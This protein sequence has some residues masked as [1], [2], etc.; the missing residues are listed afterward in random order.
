MPSNTNSTSV[1]I[2]ER[3]LAAPQYALRSVEKT[4]LLLE[5]L[6]ALTAGHRRDCNTYQRILD[7]LGRTGA[8]AFSDLAD[9]P[10]LPVR[11][12]KTMKLQSAKDTEI[13]KILT[14]SGTT[15]QQVS[16]IAVDRTTSLLQTRALA[17]IMRS[18]IGP[19]RLPMIIVDSS[20]VLRQRDS[21]NARGAGLVGMSN[22]GRDHLYVLDEDLRLNVPALMTF[23]EKHHGSE[24]LVFGFTFMVWQYFYQELRRTGDVLPLEQAVLIH[25]GGWKKLQ[26]QAVNHAVFKESLRQVCGV[27]RIHNFYGMVEQVGSIYMECEEGYFHAPHVADV[28]IRDHRDWSVLPFG[29][30]GL[31]QTLSVLP[32]S[33]PGHS[34]LTEDMAIAHGVDD[35][36]CGRNGLRFTVD[37]RMPRAELRGCSDTHAFSL[38]PVRDRPEEVRQFLPRETQAVRIESV[39]GEDLFACRPLD[40]GAPLVMDFLDT[41]SSDLLALQRVKQFPELVALAFW[42]RKSNIR[43]IWDGFVASL[44]SR[45]LAKARGMVLHIA[46]S[47][48]DTIFLYS[49]ALSLLAGNLNIVRVSRNVGQ[50]MDSLVCVLRKQMSDARW[51]PIA[52]RNRLV[53]YPR[54]ERTNRFLSAHA[55]VR[56]I[57]GGDDT[58]SAIRSVPAKPGTKDIAFADKVSATIV[59]A[60]AY[61][62]ADTSLVTSWMRAF[63]NDAYQF[64]QLACSSPHFVFFVG[65]EG[66]CE[67]ASERFWSHLAVHVSGLRTDEHVSTATDKLVAT[68]EL[69]GRAN[70]A[71][72]VCGVGSNAPVVTRIPLGEVSRSRSRTGGGFFVEC[73]IAALEDLAPVV[74]PN[75]QTLTYM[76]FTREDMAAAAPVLC[77][78]GIDRIVPVGQA[79]AFS[80]VWDGYVLLAEL[81]RRISVS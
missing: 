44:G 53:Y 46:P 6:T 65:A 3:L 69:L 50:Q 37:G 34:L 70:N 10:F 81:T 7:G 41:V 24:I 15:S 63:S 54:D 25:S 5:E 22:F 11:L 35:C 61:R 62:V 21:L 75:D 64:N 66:G 36:L 60:D 49:W 74:Q 51:L 56:V 52:E 55:D 1:D 33:Y 45:E 27:Q 19:K 12:F 26:D 73:F 17:S 47:N 28:L 77:T 48:V 8:S 59:C 4:P 42:L 39:C 18:Y 13:S 16:R 38:S 30:R 40:P 31:L 58:V 14:S 32:R 71:R 23:L 72:W 80:P 29:Q 67:E 79:L 76:G 43:R 20:A 2:T 9:L 68:Y 78:M 57:W